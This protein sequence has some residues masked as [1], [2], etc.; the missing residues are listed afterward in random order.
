MIDIK[1]YVILLT[2]HSC[3]N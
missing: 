2:K 3:R 1:N